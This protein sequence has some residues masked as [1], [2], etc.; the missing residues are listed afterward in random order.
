[1]YTEENYALPDWLSYNLLPSIQSI[2]FAFK[3]LLTWFTFVVEHIHNMFC[4]HVSRLRRWPL[5]HLISL[6]LMSVLLKSF[7]QALGDI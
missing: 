6:Y 1:M 3:L 7:A 2:L 4:C 5:K